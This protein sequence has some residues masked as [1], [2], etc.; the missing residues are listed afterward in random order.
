MARRQ[1]PDPRQ[2]TFQP[3]I[4]GTHALAQPQTRSGPN[5]VRTRAVQW[6]KGI[7]TGTRFDQDTIERMDLACARTGLGLQA[8]WEAAINWYCD[9]LGIPAEMPPGS[10]KAAIPRPSER[11]AEAGT[12][13][14]V[15]ITPNTRARLVAG[16][17]RTGL[18]G[19]EFIPQ[20]LNAWFDHLDETD[21]P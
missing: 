1:R 2:V 8:V 10:E 18:G 20:A 13:I 12:L 5:P 4:P 9:R 19:R 14:T 7:N 16:C 3:P 6:T 11:A 15:R 21:Q 17:H